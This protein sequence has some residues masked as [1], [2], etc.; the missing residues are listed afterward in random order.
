MEEKASKREQ[1]PSSSK[2]TLIQDSEVSKRESSEQPIRSGS[3]KKPLII[4]REHLFVILLVL[5][6]IVFTLFLSIRLWTLIDKREGVV[7]DLIVTLSY[8]V[9]SAPLPPHEKVLQQISIERVTSKESGDEVTQF[10]HPLPITL[11]YSRG[12]LTKCEQDENTMRVYIY[13]SNQRELIQ[14]DFEINKEE[15]SVRAYIPRLYPN[16]WNN[17]TDIILTAQESKK[18]IFGCGEDAQAYLDDGRLVFARFKLSIQLP[19]PKK[20]PIYVGGGPSFPSMAIYLPDDIQSSKEM[21]ISTLLDTE[22]LLIGQL[23]KAVIYYD[24]GSQP[25]TFIE[26]GSVLLRR[27]VMSLGENVFLIVEAAKDSRTSYF[28][29]I[30]NPIQQESDTNLIHVFSVEPDENSTQSDSDAIVQLFEDLL[31]SVQFRDY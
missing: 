22:N 21:W 23:D 2:D 15:Q 9:A 5:L 28:A 27:E 11:D 6:F 30:K 1:N 10:R 17:N 18:Y 4:A 26:E 29:F 31:A 25:A 7:G 24:E 20:R 8:S 3:L 14:L 13:N 19:D 12:Q 16:E